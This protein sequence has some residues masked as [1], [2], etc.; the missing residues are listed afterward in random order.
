M[1]GLQG[2][3]DNYFSSHD[4]EENEPFRR[5]V[6]SVIIREFYIVF[7]STVVFFFIVCYFYYG[8]KKRWILRLRNVEPCYLKENKIIIA[9]KHVLELYFC[10]T[11][12]VLARVK[13]IF[14]MVA[15][16]GK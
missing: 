15:T 6:L 5:C 11:V 7:L 8:E 1:D 9:Q 2:S 14:F 10:V 4:V 13:L 3:D 12:M 16:M